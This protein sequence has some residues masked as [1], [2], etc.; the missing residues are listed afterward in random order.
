MDLCV[1]DWKAITPIFAALIASGIASGTAFYISSKWRKQKGAEVI[2]N[3]AKQTIK[4]LLEII[5]IVHIITNKNS[6]PDESIDDFKVFKQLYEPIARSSLYINNCVEID[7]FK[8]KMEGFFNSC[9]EFMKLEPEFKP[10]FYNDEFRKNVEKKVNL[11]GS[12][13]ITMV[14][15]LIP[16][17]TYQKE[18]I[19]K[20]KK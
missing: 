16:Y 2:A 10:K 15:T 20:N 5:K 13:G 11:I 12:T 14:N 19:F 1:V 7:G 9:L 8:E 3:E 4:D 18:F 17:S 6:T